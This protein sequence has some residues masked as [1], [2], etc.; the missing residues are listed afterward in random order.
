MSIQMLACSWLKRLRDGDW[1][2]GCINWCNATAMQTAC[3]LLTINKCTFFFDRGPKNVKHLTVHC[4][5]YT[6][7]KLNSYNKSHIF[8]H[9]T[10]PSIYWLCC[11][12]P[13]FWRTVS[14]GSIWTRA[15]SR[16]PR[17]SSPTSRLPRATPARRY[18]YVTLFAYLNWVNFSLQK[19]IIRTGRP[20]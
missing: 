15:S 5:L 13:R 1:G 14:V 20:L 8:V 12:L 11:P 6:I 17:I 16:P 10:V 9:V 18:T 19:Q 3:Y 4:L 2:M 7:K